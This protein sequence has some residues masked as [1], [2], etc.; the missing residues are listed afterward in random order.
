MYLDRPSIRRIH[1]GPRPPAS[2]VNCSCRPGRSPQAVRHPWSPTRCHTTSPCSAGAAS[3][4][5]SC[6]RSSRAAGAWS[7]SRR[8][9]TPGRPLPPRPPE[10]D[11][12]PRL[13]HAQLLSL[14]LSQPH[15]DAGELAGVYR[16]GRPRPRA[17]RPSRA[18]RRHAGALGA[19][20]SAPSHGHPNRRPAAPHSPPPDPA[21][22]P[23]RR[24]PRRDHKHCPG[25]G[26]GGLSRTGLI[27]PTTDI[28]NEDRAGW[29]QDR[30]RRVRRRDR[31]ARLRLHRPRVLLG[32]RRRLDLQPPAPGRR[33]GVDPEVLLDKGRE[34][35]EAEI[36]DEEADEESRAADEQGE[37]ADQEVR[38][39]EEVGGGE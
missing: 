28:D 22:P 32:D 3:R 27:M 24:G 36:A 6:W 2:G 10:P 8:G 13:P 4:S 1:A 5:S 26:R 18:A 25:R 37:T 31:P 19:D 20:R 12:P 33:A 34:H 7:R 29:G 21:R 23:G 9:S 15:A 11:G 30:A 17:R 38:T 16:T 35:F 39:A 14:R